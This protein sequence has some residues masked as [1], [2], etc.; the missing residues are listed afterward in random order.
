LAVT[1]LAGAL[2]AG[3]GANLAGTVL[4]VLAGQ[5]SIGWANDLIDAERDAA[6]GR[7]EKPVVSGQVSAHVLRVGI[8]TA[9]GA[10]LPLSFAAFGIRGGLAHLLAVASA[11]GYNLGLKATVLSWLPYAIS[12]GLLP[13]AILMGAGHQ[14]PWQWSPAGAVLGIAA[15]LANV[16]RDIEADARVGLRGLPQ[17]LGARTSTVG[18]IVLLVVA[19]ALLFD[20]MKWVAAIAI[21]AA[22]LTLPRARRLLFPGLIALAGVD[23]LLLLDSLRP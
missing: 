5:L 10:C 7:S 23:V 19:A 13:A 20:D 12:F 14:A 17:R 11:H 22:P 21:L 1:G 16:V 6:A 15:H 2:A 9:G 4:A 3:A 8:W 18:S